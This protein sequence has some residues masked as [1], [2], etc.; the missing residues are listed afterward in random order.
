V[1][2]FF[3]NPRQRRTSRLSL[4]RRPRN[5]NPGENEALKALIAM[6]KPMSVMTNVFFM[7]FPP[8]LFDSHDFVGT[9]VH[10]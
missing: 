3:A 6:V 4:G 10:H 1:R 9:G 5:S 7:A 2:S 8:S